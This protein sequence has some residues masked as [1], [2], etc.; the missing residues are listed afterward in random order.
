[1][2][3]YKR[4]D[5]LDQILDAAERAAGNGPLDDEPEPALDLV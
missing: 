1:V 4:I 3:L 2:L 5:L